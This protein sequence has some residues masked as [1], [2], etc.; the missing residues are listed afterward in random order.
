MHTRLIVQ[1]L[2]SVKS[3]WPDVQSPIRWTKRLVKV[4]KVI[5]VKRK[6]LRLLLQCDDY[7]D[8][9]QKCFFL[10]KYQKNCL[11]YKM[12]IF[13]YK[14]VIKPSW[15]RGPRRTMILF[16]LH[17]LLCFLRNFRFIPEI[18]YVRACRYR[19]HYHVKHTMP[20][21]D[22]ESDFEPEITLL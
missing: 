11:N 6:V 9:V 14:L 19:L 5:E 3:L 18:F 8:C 4:Q 7:S 17:V 22:T 12:Q 20:D 2:R 10:H 16:D 1:Y 21:T 13:A 15:F